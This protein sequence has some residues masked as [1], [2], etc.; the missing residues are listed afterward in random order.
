MRGKG[1]DKY[2]KQVAKTAKGKRILGAEE[3]KAKRTAIREARRERKRKKRKKG[4][5]LSSGLA[6]AT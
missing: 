6:A 5:T 3:H 4:M 1:L 2:E